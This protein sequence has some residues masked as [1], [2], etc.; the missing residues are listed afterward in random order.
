[1]RIAF[2]TDPLDRLDPSTDT[3]VGLMHAADGRD[4]EVWVTQAQ[5]LEAV[6]GRARALAR[7]VRL[8]PSRPAGDHRWTV[9]QPWYTTAEPQH[10]WLDE[11]AAVLWPANCSARSGP[12]PPPD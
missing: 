6:H 2:V 8:A 5:S 4:A 10:V 11:M 9:A 12:V 3:S 7:Q 1:M